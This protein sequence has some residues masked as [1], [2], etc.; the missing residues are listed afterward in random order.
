MKK[1]FV[2]FTLLLYCVG[3][4]Y[5]AHDLVFPSHWLLGE[6]H[7]HVIEKGTLQFFAPYTGNVSIPPYVYEYLEGDHNVHKITV[8][9]SI[10]G[11]SHDGTWVQAPK[12]DHRNTNLRV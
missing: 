8:V 7:A 3:S 5:A 6:S 2:S 1:Y 4:I 9:S 11:S 10:C 12:K